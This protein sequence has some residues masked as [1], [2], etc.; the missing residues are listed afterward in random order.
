[1]VVGGRRGSQARSVVT[2]THECG[3]PSTTRS[4]TRLDQPHTYPVRQTGGSSS[5]P[6]GRRLPNKNRPDHHGD[7]PDRE[8]RH[9]QGQHQRQAPIT[10]AY[11]EEQEDG[12]TEHR[13]GGVW[14]EGQHRA[15]DCDASF[16]SGRQDGATPQRPAGGSSGRDGRDET[17]RPPP[18]SAT[19]P[20][21]NETKPIG[22]RADSRA[23]P[24]RTSAETPGEPS[25]FMITRDHSPRWIV[26]SRVCSP[27]PLTDATQKPLVPGA[28]GSV[29]PSF[30]VYTTSVMSSCEGVPGGDLIVD[31]AVQVPGDRIGGSD[32]HEERSR[33][34]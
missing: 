3:R 12:G 5:L 13:P 32:A 15:Q 18:T 7:Q 14:D 25:A 24:N 2:A 20:T 33:T 30:L 23:T 22:R 8:E 26:Q 31:D 17:S 1:M 27:L 9:E 16:N 4:H 6:A 19:S 10:L 29:A 34:P 21:T 28:A 11:G